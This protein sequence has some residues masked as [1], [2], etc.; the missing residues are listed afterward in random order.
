MQD[1]YKNY[2]FLTLLGI[3]IYSC[4]GTTNIK[5][6]PNTSGAQ[7]NGA[8]S[9]FA[10]LD[11]NLDPLDL[12]DQARKKTGP[13]RDALQL[14]AAQIY[15]A[16]NKVDKARNLANS[17]DKTRL[18]EE[19]FVTYS[20]VIALLALNDNDLSAARRILTNPRVERNISALDPQQEA[21]LR[22]TRAQVFERSGF[23]KES[24]DERISLSTI[25][26]DKERSDSNQAA[27]WKTLM[28]LPLAKLQANALKGAGGITQGWYSLAALS[29]NN[30]Q[31]LATQQAQLSK[32][33]TQWRNHPANENLPKDLEVLNSLV[34]AQPQKIAL[35]LPFKGR[36]AEAGAAV[37]D[38]FFAAYYNALNQSAHSSN[39][40]SAQ[41]NTHGSQNP[42][43]RQYDSSMG[44]VAAYQLAVADGAN[45]IIGPLEK[46]DVNQISQLPNLPVPLLSLNY[47]D[48]QPVTLI[49]GFYQFGLAVE[50]EARQ[51]AREAI[52]NGFSRALV[53][54][55]TQEWSE[56]S[57]Q[58]FI[59]EWQTLGGALVGKIQFIKQNQLSDALRNVMLIDESQQRMAL[60]QQQLA[61]KFEFN[62][63]RRDDVDLVFM[64]VTPAQG[65]QIRPT[66]AFHYANN[67]PTFATSNIYSGDKDAINNEDLNGVIFNTLPWLFDNNNSAKQAIAQTTKSSAVYS[68]LHALGA[69]SFHL[70]ARIPQLKLAP[71]MKLYG[72]TGSLRLVADGRIERDQIWA[73]FTAGLV[74]P[75]ATIPSINKVPQGE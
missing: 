22:E 33:L 4:G 17:I 56:R 42:S 20:Q 50:D 60:L 28:E 2:I 12:L 57:A 53:V 67:I 54:V 40:N 29:K 37:R 43:V 10:G 38:G 11:H 41:A 74:E 26:T 19:A 25:L 1:R 73:Q 8:Q 68:R 72:T 61:T 69:D 46:E 3:L 51:I 9:I 7:Q 36:L 45:F 31:N 65:R 30:T 16:Q 55:P 47:P 58:A 27:L 52:A 64:P 18:N 32:W 5:D 62:P 6:A 34:R 70:Y 59:D 39:Q 44:A 49:N 24:I 14:Q 66:F 21:S 63:R 35:L 15:L 75:I 13:E 23:L 48:K 71:E